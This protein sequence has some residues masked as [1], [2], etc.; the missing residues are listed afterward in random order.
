MVSQ[1]VGFSRVTNAL[2]IKADV[3]KDCTTGVIKVKV[4][5]S[6]VDNLGHVGWALGNTIKEHPP[7]IEL[8]M[9]PRDQGDVFGGCRE[10]A[11]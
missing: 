5:G 9:D 7:V 8:V 4:S 1:P 10:P 11:L 2:A 3:I 6:Q